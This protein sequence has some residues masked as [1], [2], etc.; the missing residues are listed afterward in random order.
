MELPRIGKS[1]GGMLSGIK[2]KLGLGD[3]N[4]GAYDDEY[5]DD[6]GDEYGEGYEE[7]YGEYGEGYSD[8]YGYEERGSSRSARTG[9][10]SAS[11]PRLVSIDDVRPPR[12]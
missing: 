10:H 4:N 11:S 6:Y 8:D 12:C 1:D 7:D 5:Y 3:S 9:A 2:S